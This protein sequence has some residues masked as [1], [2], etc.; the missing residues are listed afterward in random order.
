[1]GV[2]CRL[3]YPNIVRTYGSVSGPPLC[4]VME[5]LTCSLGD[6]FTPDRAGRLL[7]AFTHREAHDVAIGVVSGV[8]VLRAGNIVHGDLRRE[9][10]LLDG[11]MTA[12]VWA[13]LGT[14]RQMAETRGGT[15][16][17]PVAGHYCAPER[18]ARA[19]NVSGVAV[20]RA[21]NIVHG[22]L[23]RENVPLD[24]DMT[25]RVGSTW[26]PRGRWRRWGVTQPR[27]R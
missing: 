15:A 2:S 13:D 8:A 23:R 25:A 17:A 6:L 9:N 12:R 20:L 14:A 1:M 27:R 22:D 21:G 10:V 24:G 19:P 18:V 7:G 11:D 16:A 26:A 4:I 3:V 5:A